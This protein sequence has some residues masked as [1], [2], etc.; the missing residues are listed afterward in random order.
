MIPALTAIC[1]ISGTDLTPSF[2]QMLWLFRD[3]VGG[4]AKGIEKEKWVAVIAQTISAI[5][6]ESEQIEAAMKKAA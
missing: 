2:S 1:M 5:Q 3:F 6:K 4:V